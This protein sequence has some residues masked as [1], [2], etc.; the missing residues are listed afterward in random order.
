VKFSS[1]PE[2]QNP[3]H[4]EHT[5]RAFDA[6]G[7]TLVGEPSRAELHGLPGVVSGLYRWGAGSGGGPDS[8]L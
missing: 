3:L 8:A 1:W 6:V 5:L 2:A 7:G 4:L